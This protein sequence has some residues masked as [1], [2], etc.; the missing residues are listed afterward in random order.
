MLALVV[1]C[2]V[3]TSAVAQ[4]AA[5]PKWGP[6]IDLEAKPGTKRSLS[7]AD[8]FIPVAQS[9]DT[10]LFA[11]LRLR[12]DDNDS[13]EGN[14][15]LGVRH[16]LESGWNLGAYGYFDR[17][18][19]EY[20]NHFNQV[21][22]GVEAL[23]QDW[24]LRA[25][26]YAPVGRR[27][28]NI[29]SL[30]TAEVSG[31]TVIFRGGEERSMGGFDAEVGRRVP[32]FDASADRQFRIFGGAYHFSES[33]VEDISGPRARAELTFDSV[34]YLWEGSRFSIGA[35]WQHDDP[36]G[37]QGF[38]TARL[39]IPFQVYGRPA[40]TLTPMERRMADPVVRDIDVVSQAGQ[41]SAPETATQLANGSTFTV[42][43]SATTAGDDL[44]D[45]VTAA[46]NNSTVILAGAFQTTGLN[47][48]SLAFNQTLT[49]FAT[50]RSASGRTAVVNTGASINGTNMTT[51]TVQL[52]AG[53]RLEGVT[54]TGAY[55]G[56][57][58]GRVVQVAD[59]STGVHI[60]NSIIT[61]TQSGAAVG[62][63]VT[64]GQN[65][66]V[67]LRNNT[68]TA[69]GSGTATTMT[70]LFASS[71]NTTLTFTGN[72]ISATGGTTNNIV[73]FG[74]GVTTITGDSTGNIRGSGNCVGTPASGSIGFTNGTTCP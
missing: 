19:T 4:S 46:G 48:V 59:G 70:A 13:N 29:D 42:L 66:S 28:H 55:S 67:T 21:T 57:A 71:S 51:T 43:N 54:V 31:T 8:L 16:M 10:L 6:H 74:A 18:R 22:L 12:M 20:D 27:S 34:P 62:N 41:F 52:N 39:R 64:I 2:A 11:N 60:E 73:N 24:D 9:A 40:S 33:G 45:V 17:R 23:S 49:G 32:L 63:V 14:Y 56:G 68:I 58:A 1:G 69:S 37:S 26:Y 15:G 36:R 38:L 53:G 72:T 50:V 25:N 30:N 7:E 5:E 44:D 65:T 3:T 47:A 35:E 61:G